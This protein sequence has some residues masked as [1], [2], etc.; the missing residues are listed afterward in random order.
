MS[1][2]TYELL[3]PSPRATRDVRSVGR[4]R[5]PGSEERNHL[6]DISVIFMDIS[7]GRGG[8]SFSGLFTGRLHYV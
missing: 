4:G 2:A 5:K 1:L 3:P 6:L 8:S 7:T